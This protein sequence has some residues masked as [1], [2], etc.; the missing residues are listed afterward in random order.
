[1]NVSLCNNKL[2]FLALASCFGS[3]CFGQGEWSR[4]SDSINPQA[5]LS[6]TT[7][8]RAYKD[9]EE[10]LNIP[11]CFVFWDY[12]I[13]DDKVHRQIIDLY[14]QDRSIFMLRKVRQEEWDKAMCENKTRYPATTPSF[15]HAKELLHKKICIEDYI[16]DFVLDSFGAD[17]PLT[18]RRFDKIEQRVAWAGHIKPLISL[19]I[20]AILPEKHKLPWSWKNVAACGLMG[21]G[22]HLW[23][24]KGDI[25]PT[26]CVLG[27]ASDTLANLASYII[28]DPKLLI[29]NPL[30]DTI[31]Y[32]KIPAPPS[33]SCSKRLLG[34]F[35]VHY[36]AAGVPGGILSSLVTLA[37]RYVAHHTT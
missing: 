15:E 34:H 11:T 26:P 33:W 10:R 8:L 4:R 29:I 16:E 31:L 32:P 17:S 37:K 30:I 1:M 27:Y 19:A 5:L 13:F 36:H 7:D 35:Y 23:N 22:I 25:E 9:L 12:F 18:L 6:D 3:S 28:G 14:D 21:L 24:K 20:A 2:F